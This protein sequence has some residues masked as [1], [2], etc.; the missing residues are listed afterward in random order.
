MNNKYLIICMI[1]IAAVYN[2]AE[3]AYN[4]IEWEDGYFINKNVTSKGD[5]LIVFDGN[6]WNKY[7]T[8]FLPDAF[9]E[10]SIETRMET[11]SNV[12]KG[13]MPRLAGAH[14]GMVAS[15]GLNRGDSEFLI[16]NAVKGMGFCPDEDHIDSILELL[17]STINAEDFEIKLQTLENLYSNAKD[18]YAHDKLLSLELYSEPQFQTGT[19]I[20]QYMNPRVSIVF[21]DIPSYEVKAIAQMYHPDNPEL[22]DYEKKVVKYANLIHSYFHGDFEKTFIAVVY[23]TIEVFDNSPGKGGKGMRIMPLMP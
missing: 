18:I 7:T 17:E 9:I 13:K 19:F 20:N 10:W 1:L 4:P 2:Y 21:L 8:T 12:R 11:F 16:N 5:T 15:Y 14:N 23:N 22:T 6:V 3:V